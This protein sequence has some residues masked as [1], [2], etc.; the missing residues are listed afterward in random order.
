MRPARA[1]AGRR[2]RR[3]PAARVRAKSVGWQPSTATALPPRIS[4]LS[5]RSIRAQAVLCFKA[6]RQPTADA[7]PMAVDGLSDAAPLEILAIDDR[8][9]VIAGLEHEQP[10]YYLRHRFGY[11]VH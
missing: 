7:V 4:D 10:R 5:R 2:P 1:R 11:Q 8:A 6:H 3:H 9:V